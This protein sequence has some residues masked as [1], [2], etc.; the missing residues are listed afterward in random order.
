[1]LLAY[2]LASR[3]DRGAQKQDGIDRLFAA[4]FLIDLDTALEV[5]SS[6]VRDTRMWQGFRLRHNLLFPL[7]TQELLRF[8]AASQSLRRF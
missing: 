3:L 1:L 7:G 5:F 2:L 4:F 6:T 8:P